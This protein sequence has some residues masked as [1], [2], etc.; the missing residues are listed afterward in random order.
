MQPALP[1]GFSPDLR[2][3]TKTGYLHRTRSRY[4]RSEKGKSSP[5]P[6]YRLIP[7]IETEMK[8]EKKKRIYSIT[9]AGLNGSAVAA[10]TCSLSSASVTWTGTPNS[11][12]RNVFADSNTSC[13]LIGSWTSGSTT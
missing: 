6:D 8:E 12:S 3:N 5:F 2:I 10:F 11:C 7:G 1:V 4:I 13:S 9:I